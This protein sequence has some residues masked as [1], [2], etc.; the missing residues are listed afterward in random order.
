MLTHRDAADAPDR[1]TDGQAEG[2][3]VGEV[4]PV[5][6]LETPQQRQRH[7]RRE[8]GPAGE[9]QPALP[10]RERLPERVELVEVGD[11][12]R[13]AGAHDA[14]QHQPGRQPEHLVPGQP[15]RPAVPPGD[16]RAHEHPDQHAQTE[17]L[18]SDRT[19]LDV[20]KRGVRNPEHARRLPIVRSVAGARRIV[21]AG[22]RRRPASP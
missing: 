14:G 22:V 12:V 2:G 19:D 18:H 4:P 21:S 8:D 20:G 5:D 3:R 7:Q 10:D 1:L 11:H 16:E 6:R 17:D 13:E 15:A 9:L